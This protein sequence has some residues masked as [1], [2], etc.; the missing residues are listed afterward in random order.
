MKIDEIVNEIASKV[1]ISHAQA[2]SAFL[3]SVEYIKG[4][5]P[6][7]VGSQVTGLLEGKEFDAS[8]I[9]KEQAQEKFEELKHDATEAFENLKEKGKN[10]FS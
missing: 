1:G 6:D 5:L 8:A 7:S 10:F 4:K 9:I 2:Q 3:A